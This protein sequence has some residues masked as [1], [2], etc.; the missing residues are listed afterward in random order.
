MPTGALRALKNTSNS[1]KST[2]PDAEIPFLNT[3]T[4]E[5]SLKQRLS[6]LE[7]END[8]LRRENADLRRENDELKYNLKDTEAL[9]GQHVVAEKRRAQQGFTAAPLIS[10]LQETRCKRGRSPSLEILDAPGPSRKQLKKSERNSVATLQVIHSEVGSTKAEITSPLKAVKLSPSQ[11]KYA[12]VEPSPV[13]EPKRGRASDKQNSGDGTSSKFVHTTEALPIDNDAQIDVDEDE[14]DPNDFDDTSVSSSRFNSAGPSMQ[15][16]ASP[17]GKKLEHKEEKVKNVFNLPTST[18]KEYIGTSKRLTI[19]PPPLDLEVPRTFLRLAYGGSDQH[20]LQ[21]I[22]KEKNP[23]GPHRRR[24][25]F[26]MLDMNPAM[27]SEPGEPGLVFASRHEILSNPPWSLFCKHSK[28]APAVWRY[29]GDYENTLCGTMTAEEFK[30]QTPTTKLEWAKLIMK[31]KAFDVYVGMRARIA[32]RKFKLLP[33]KNDQDEQ[34]MVNAEIEAIKKGKGRNVTESEIITAFSKGEEGIDIIRMTCVKYDHVFAQDM[35]DK[36][37]NY[38]DL[39]LANKRKNETQDKGKTLKSRVQLLSE[40]RQR[41]TRVLAAR[42]E[43]GTPDESVVEDEDQEG[44]ADSDGDYSIPRSHHAASTS[45]SVPA[46]RARPRR[47]AARSLSFAYL[48]GDDDDDDDG[49]NESFEPAFDGDLTDI[50][51]D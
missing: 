16:V 8:D 21:F 41:G 12:K 33:A 40:R 29:L 19:N 1:S 34:K 4:A 18:I 11:K 5:L 22:P 20:F 31:M 46:S 25:V 32:L 24:I 49:D 30:A 10:N 23:S 13:K 42:S 17:K 38:D 39:K 3:Q 6:A 43:V 27:P 14:V 50:E 36:Y 7:R 35:K 48:N 9:L 37:V 28:S 26:P 2:D 51:D 15:S 45:I 44:S 47:A